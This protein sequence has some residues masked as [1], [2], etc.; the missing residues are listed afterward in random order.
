M[1]QSYN[2]QVLIAG[3]RSER[4]EVDMEDTGLKLLPGEDRT[5]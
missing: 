4:R 1:K 2:C 3:L 5:S